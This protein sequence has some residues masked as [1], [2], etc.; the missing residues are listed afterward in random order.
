MG[1]GAGLSQLLPDNTLGQASREGRDLEV[2]C[3]LPRATWGQT[4]SRATS[5]IASRWGVA[6][7]K[8]WVIDSKILSHGDEVLETRI[9][10]FQVILSGWVF[11]AS[12]PQPQVLPE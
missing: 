10:R 7:L 1:E 9:H 8:Q 5:A 11:M 2:P 4:C 6:C 12:K 3:Q